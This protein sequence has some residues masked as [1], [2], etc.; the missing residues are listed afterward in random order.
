M[1]IER[2]KVRG[3]QE[4]KKMSIDGK[5]L[6]WAVRAS[7]QCYCCPSL[8][9]AV[10]DR[11]TLL[12]GCFAKQVGCSLVRCSADR[13]LLVMVR[14]Y[15][16]KTLEKKTDDEGRNWGDACSWSVQRERRFV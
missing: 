16:R 6:R 1:Q 9:R 13:F 7:M 10:C 5:K 8:L 4:E 15:I 3:R 12:V 14:T 2:K 11:R